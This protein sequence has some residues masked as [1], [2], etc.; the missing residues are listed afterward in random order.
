MEGG[1]EWGF[2]PKPSWAKRPSA[3][4]PEAKTEAAPA[5]AAG[6]P[7]D[8]GGEGV[9]VTPA[10]ELELPKLEKRLPR[11][12]LSI[13]EVESIMAGP[14][15]AANIG[16]RDRAILET[17]YS[18]GMR[19]MAV[20]NL[21]VFDLDAERGTVMVR[22]GKK[23]RMVPIG[24]RALTWIQKYVDD[25]RQGLAVTPDDGVLF[26]AADGEAFTPNRLTQLVREYVDKAKLKKRG[27]C[28]L[29]RHTMAT[30][31]LEGGAD[32]TTKI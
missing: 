23:D 25:V 17:L 7:E 21:K 6:T 26:L 14:D 29:F 22:Q 32:L 5:S 8:V 4:V 24:E 11:A 12:V 1:S 9:L 3:A 20:V 27:S 28:H 30:L 13:T 31:M 16:V 18:T 19:R 15:V 2:G 10:S